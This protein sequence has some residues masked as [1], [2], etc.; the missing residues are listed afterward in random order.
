M[1][2]YE[3]FLEREEER[4]NHAVNTGAGRILRPKKRPKGIPRT[5]NSIPAFLI[6]VILGWGAGLITYCIIHIAK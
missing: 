6:G 4:M 5:T 2:C 3:S 1:N